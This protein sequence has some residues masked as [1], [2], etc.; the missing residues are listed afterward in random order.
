MNYQAQPHTFHLH[1]VTNQP[2]SYEVRDEGESC[3]GMVRQAESG[4]D[5]STRPTTG[6]VT[7]LRAPTLQ[8]AVAHIIGADVP[9]EGPQE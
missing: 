5:W 1:L 3:W 8:E 4:A 7:T 2:R 9:Y 6:D